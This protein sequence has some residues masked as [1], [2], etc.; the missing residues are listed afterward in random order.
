MQWILTVMMA[1]RAQASAHA[2]TA[3]TALT[4]AFGHTPRHHRLSRLGAPCAPRTALSGA[5]IGGSLG[6]MM[7]SW[8][9]SKGID[10][11]ALSQQIDGAL[12]VQSVIYPEWQPWMLVLA[13]VASSVLAIVAA[14]LPA[15]LSAQADP[16]TVMQPRK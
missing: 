6:A 8:M 9:G 7:S 4:V 2:T 16:A 5:L 15:Y 3:P 14:L 11:R 12:T 10:L 13:V 1:A